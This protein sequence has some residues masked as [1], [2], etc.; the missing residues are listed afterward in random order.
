MIVAII[1]A[2][3]GSSRLPNKV[4]KKI[5][6]RPLIG[7]LLGSVSKVKQISKLI[8]AT[9]TKKEDD[10]LVEYVQALGY[11]VYRGSEDDVLQRYYEA[12]NTLKN[13][14][15]YYGIVRLTGDCPLL[16]SQLIDNI[17]TTFLDNN[18]DH[19]CLSP[20]YSEGLD[21]EI[22]KPALLLEAYT[23]AVNISEREH[24]M[25]Y[26]SNNK[27]KFNMYQLPSKTDDSKYRIT[28]DEPEDFEVVKT[29]IEEFNKE[30]KELTIEN[31][32]SFLEKNKDIHA[33]NSTIIRNEGLLKS[34][35]NDKVVK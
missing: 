25:L 5:L 29:I 11:E 4:M 30:N 2:R 1:Q 16:Q 34:I 24:V 3:M 17:I 21:T 19:V 35:Q 28:V 20:Q 23:N 26:V 33:L 13:K 32:K 15:A 22:F 10:P 6:G 27:D 18:Y 14:E 12:F 8:V 9:T 7:Y 31:I